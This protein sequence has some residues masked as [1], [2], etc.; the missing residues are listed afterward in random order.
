MS[1]G[2]VALVGIFFAMIASLFAMALAEIRR[3]RDPGPLPIDV[4]RDIEHR[5]FARV[6]RGLPMGDVA[7]AGDAGAADAPLLI[8]AAPTGEGTYM[9]RGDG[10]VPGGGVLDAFVCDGIATVGP[11]AAVLEHVDGEAG[12]VVGA[13]A[14]VGG[15]ATSATW[16]LLAPGSHVRYAAAPQ[17]MTDG[18]TVPEDPAALAVWDGSMD[19]DLEWLITQ[20]MPVD[21]ALRSLSRDQGR[22]LDGIA[23]VSALEA[24]TGIGAATLDLGAAINP[25]WLRDAEGWYLGAAT[26]R[27]PGDLALPA[28]AVVPFHLIVDGTLVAREG[29]HF[30][31]GVSVRGDAV[32][33]DGCRVERSLT[34]K[35]NVLLSDRCSVGECVS[36]G[37][38]A[39]LGASVLIGGVRNG[40]LASTGSVALGPGV[41]VT[42]KIYADGGI[43][44]LAPDAAAL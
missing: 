26:A 31:G 7:T 22:P 1:L 24:R 16:I 35:G 29:V 33:F 2:Y 18:P 34:A 12:L 44:V 9:M 20:G 42:N 41:R 27:I 43:V 30:H 40:G 3:P 14:S 10:D 25:W 38:D 15:R 32:L 36:A 19:V 21:Q 28:G 8:F 39:T 5:W 13:G 11:G 6:L 4:G 37:G 17:I 23:A